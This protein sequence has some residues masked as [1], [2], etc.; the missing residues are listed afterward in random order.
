MYALRTLSGGLG[1]AKM[2]KRALTASCLQAQAQLK[3]RGNAHS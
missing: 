1:F 3:M 2:A